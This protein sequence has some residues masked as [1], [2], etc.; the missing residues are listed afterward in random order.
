M[1]NSREGYFQ[2]Q[3]LHLQ[4]YYYYYFTQIDTI[5]KISHINKENIQLNNN[6]VISEILV[7]RDH[8]M[9]PTKF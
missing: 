2:K 8:F 5:K 9:H 3:N 7:V 1:N 4:Y 6:I